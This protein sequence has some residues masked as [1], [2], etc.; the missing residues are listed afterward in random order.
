MI[1]KK[2]FILKFNT[3]KRKGNMHIKTVVFQYGKIFQGLFLKNVKTPPCTKDSFINGNDF[4]PF[5]C[6]TFII[7]IKCLELCDSEGFFV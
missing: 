4:F 7:Q 3:R 2:I 5:A 1:R 6:K